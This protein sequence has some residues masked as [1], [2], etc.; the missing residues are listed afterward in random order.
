MRNRLAYGEGWPFHHH[1]M[2]LSFNWWD[3]AATRNQMAIDSS[4]I[5]CGFRFP[6]DGPIE[7]YRP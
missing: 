1:H 4:S 6:G 5:G 2:H 3:Q 7:E